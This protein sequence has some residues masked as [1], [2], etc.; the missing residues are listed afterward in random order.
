V[1]VVV[2]AVTNIDDLLR[3]TALTSMSLRKKTRS[4]SATPNPRS[5]ED[6]AWR[7]QF[8]KVVAGAGGLAAGDADDIAGGFQGLEAGRASE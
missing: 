6:A 7:A 8:A 1:N 3:T 5:G 4:G 2:E